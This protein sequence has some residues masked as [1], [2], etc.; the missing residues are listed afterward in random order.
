MSKT[1]RIFISSP[2]DVSAEREKARQVITQLERRYDGAVKLVPVLWEDLPLG[3][4]LS[5]QEGIDH[6]LSGGGGI[7]LAVFIL[8]SRLGSPLGAR[9]SRSD[10][11]GYRRGTEREWDMM[12]E[13]RRQSGG[14]RP[15]ILAYLRQDEAGFKRRL[16]EMPA[17]RLSEEIQQQ[18]LAQEFVREVFHDPETRAN[19]RAYHTFAEPLT[20]A[21][22]LRVH[23]RE[24]LDTMLGEELAGGRLLDGSPYLAFDVFE[25]AHAE[26]FHGRERELAD[27]E[28][29]LRSKPEQAFVVVV[30][31][32]GSGKSSLVRAGL[33]ASL[34]RFNLDESVAQWRVAVLTPARCEGDLLLGLARVLCSGSCL[35]EA[36]ENGTTPESLA[37]AFAESPGSA[38]RLALLPALDRAARACGGHIKLLLIVDQLEETH[39]DPRFGPATRDAF[40]RCLQVLAASG[41]FWIAAT[42]R[43]DLYG[44]LQRDPAFLELKGAGGQFDLPPPAPSAMRRMITAP[45]RLAGLV[46][47]K[48]ERTGATLDQ[49]LLDEA[50]RHPDALPLLEFSLHELYERRQN[51]TL[52]FAAY[53]DM[54]G[55]AGAAGSGGGGRHNSLPADVRAA[56]PALFQRLVALDPLQERQPVR[57]ASV[58]DPDDVS[59]PGGRLAAA[60]VL[61]R[62]LTT[63]RD[64]ERP[65]LTLAHEA[66]LGAWGDLAAWVRENHHLLRL[67]SRVE[68]A[69]ARWA[70]GGRNPSLLLPPGLPLEEGCRL[71]ATAPVL[72]NSELSEFIELSSRSFQQARNKNRRRVALTLSSLALLGIVG[73]IAAVWFAERARAGTQRLAAERLLGA[74]LSKDVLQLANETGRFDMAEKIAANLKN[75]MDTVPLHGGRRAEDVIVRLDLNESTALILQNSG[76]KERAMLQARR[77]VEMAEELLK[78]KPDDEEALYRLCRAIS[79]LAP[80]PHSGDQ[81]DERLAL[82][83]R[84]E[85]LFQAAG[86]ALGEARWQSLLGGQQNQ[87]AE[88]VSARA[89][90]LLSQAANDFQAGR[91]QDYEKA[92]AEIRPQI[93]ELSRMIFDHR[94]KAREH[95]RKARELE[96]NNNDYLSQLSYA[97]LALADD[98]RSAGER[99]KT[100]PALSQRKDLV[101]EATELARQYL[102]RLP[103][104]DYANYLMINCMGAAAKFDFESGDAAKALSWL[105]DSLELMRSMTLRSRDHPSRV[106]ALVFQM[107]QLADLKAK[108]GDFTSA[109][110]LLQQARDWLPKLQAHPKFKDTADALEKLIEITQRN[111]AGREDQSLLLDQIRGNHASQ[112]AELVLQSIPITEAL[113]SQEKAYRAAGL[114]GVLAELTDFWRPRLTRGSISDALRETL[115]VYQSQPRD[116]TLHS[117]YLWLGAGF[118]AAA[119]Q[120]T[121]GQAEAALQTAHDCLSASVIADAKPGENAILA[122]LAKTLAA[123]ESGAGKNDS[124][125][126]VLQQWLSF[127][128]EARKNAS[129]EEASSAGLSVVEALNEAGALHFQMGRLDE[130]ENYYQQALEI[131]LPA[132]ANASAGDKPA[133]WHARSAVHLNLA[134]TALARI[135]SS[136]SG[137]TAALK[138]SDAAHLDKAEAILAELAKLAPPP[139]GLDPLTEFLRGLRA[140]LD[141][142]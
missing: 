70:E 49:L 46:F 134:E 106:Q 102:Q 52:T 59:S 92:L 123:W 85:A 15:H 41:R 132:T 31:P 87:R 25:P 105:E 89:S 114:A 77:Q 86:P 32:S 20:F 14:R 83:E 71:I 107:Q 22:R 78:T 129:P 67:R 40:F 61:A 33:A 13:A 50:S 142:P 60:L 65:T 30:G 47:E 44:A 93:E 28:D 76:D 51:R 97:L 95:Y 63:G 131:L 23:L 136:P 37:A 42:L 88:I 101:A 72:L 34:A 69:H 62:L 11:S 110:K 140:Q 56:L 116:G 115:H 126:R 64:S 21:S 4:D 138:A 73:A 96:P 111:F 104:H 12:M 10:G 112:L 75:Y 8:W 57:R 39:T 16:Q 118:L 124:A 1:I 58:Y 35:P 120:H 19:L 98:L 84:R 135:P 7:D 125:V 91:I 94:S 24:F 9:I 108:S 26:I 5:F 29:M 139:P 27:L 68:Q 117:R 127:A 2:G 113:D 55:I 36:R 141:K 122:K 81:A 79:G 99:L 38:L 66:L 137:R 103:E 133:E 80:M 18:L 119:L 54:G 45:A 3:A 100:G 82:L 6:I 128:L 74:L 130:A 48:D 43:S 121:T 90:A 109:G 53:R 17:E